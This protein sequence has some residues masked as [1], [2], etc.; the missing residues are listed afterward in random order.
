MCYL[1]IQYPEPDNCRQISL[2]ITSSLYKCNIINCI[3]NMTQ[4]TGRG[5]KWTLHAPVVQISITWHGMPVNTSQV[6]QISITQ[7]GMQ[8]IRF[9][10]VSRGWGVHFSGFSVYNS[11]AGNEVYTSQ[12]VQ[13]SIAQQGMRCTLLRFFSTIAQQGMQLN[14]S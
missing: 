12:V 1:S 7:K 5:C 3:V 2:F 11:S 13:C 10:Q 6:V 4:V 14:A 9:Q 8:V